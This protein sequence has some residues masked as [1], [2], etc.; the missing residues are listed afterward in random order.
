MS[1]HVSR[2]ALEAY[3]MG[4]LDDAELEAVEAHVAACSAC[5]ARLQHEARLEMAFAR[6]A[7]HVAP[8]RPR[9]AVRVAAP[10]AA[11]G[12]VLAVAAAMMLWLAPRGDV[13]ARAPDPIPETSG[14]TTGDA[15]TATAQLE[16]PG[17][18]AV[19]AAFR[20]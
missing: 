17:D 15:S 10:L 9:R 20:D 5:E 8:E 6:V 13:D 1:D 7:D 11:T 16:V 19:R 3:V 14:D 12:G 18:G 2:D 4:A